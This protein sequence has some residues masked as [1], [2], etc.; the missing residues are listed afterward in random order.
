MSARILLD[1][2]VIIHLGRLEEPPPEAAE[3]AVSAL[4]VAEL[5]AGVATAADDRERAL[6]M[7]RLGQVLAEIAVL[8]FDG[9]AARAYGEV[10]ASLRRTGRRE[11]ARI[12][13]VLIASTAIAHGL[14]LYTVNARDFV[15]MDGLDVH[16]LSSIRTRAADDIARGDPEPATSSPA[17][18]AG[19]P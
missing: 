11:R 6:R 10:V 15:G 9:L 12:M 7:E 2:S 3:P 8:P 19:D 13:D 17:D 18:L 1:T 4:T 5:H 16:P 14:A